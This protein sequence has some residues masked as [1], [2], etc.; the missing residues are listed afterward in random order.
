MGDLKGRRVVVTGGGSGIG[1]ETARVLAGQGAEVC[2]VGRRQGPLADAV[3]S[4]G[5][6]AWSHGCDVSS[7]EQI[8][9]LAEAVDGRWGG[10]DGLVNN[11]GISPMA[12]LDDTGAE[13][14]DQVFAINVRGPYL[15]CRALGSFLKKGVSPA[16]V[17]VSSSLAVKAIPGMAAYNAS[18]AALNQLT[19]SLALEWAPAVR[20]NAVMPGVVD[21]PIHG[22]RGMDKAAVEHMARIHPL[23]RIGRPADVA[24]LIVFLLS[25]ASSWMTGAVIPIDGGMIAT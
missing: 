7:P 12:S 22:G 19:R 4:L 9:G 18:K 1:L 13:L 2:V 15:G 24:A 21:T 25:D 14:W 3:E 10:L 6:A 17:N 16:V 5:P 8:A 20:V 11:A 23:Q